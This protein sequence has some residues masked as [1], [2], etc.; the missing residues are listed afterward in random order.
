MLL[1]LA[2]SDC[3]EPAHIETGSAQDG[4][5]EHAQNS[6]IVLSRTQREI[7][8]IAVTRL[9]RTAL[10]RVIRA[11]GEV[12]TNA[13]TTNIVAPRVTA[14][15][16][17][18]SAELGEHVGGGMRLV[19]LYSHDMAEA[20]GAFL[21][22]ERELSRQRGLFAAD[23]TSAQSLDQA[24]AE[25]QEASGRLESYG[26]TGG[27]IAALIEAGLDNAR[28][29]QFVLLAPGAGTIIRDE[30]RIGDVVEGGVPL[31][32]IADLSNVW[33]EAH[34]SPAVLPEIADTGMIRF[35][36]NSREA[37]IVQRRDTL[38]EA[39][40]TLGVRLEADNRDGSLRPG[41]FVDVEL[42]GDDEDVLAV[43]SEAVL[44]SP[45]G[46]WTVYV[47]GTDDTFAA[48]EVEILFE[49][50]GQAAIAGLDEG[51]PVV[52]SGAF[53]V[54]AEAAKAGFDVHAH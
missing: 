12:Q 30:F 49:A 11:P 46:D 34:V 7:A 50:R 6:G 28:I 29:G 18:R 27:Q 2:L 5:D 51:T 26:L 21:L 25:R 39:T 22:A 9:V 3:S 44:Q 31:F 4:A 41:Q 54:A 47:E 38:N 20:Q 13:Y 23:A 36:T 16:V 40:R 10:P 43:P 8:G 15:I 45:D 35:G 48:R 24:I 14:T 32:E 19:T 33:I 53:F 37:V 17:S 52:T 42:Y 1:G